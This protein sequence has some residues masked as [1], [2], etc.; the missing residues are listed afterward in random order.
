MLI[1]LERAQGSFVSL[2]K[3]SFPMVRQPLCLFVGNVFSLCLG[4]W[5]GG[6]GGKFLSV[7]FLC[8][9]PL[10]GYLCVSRASYVYITVLKYAS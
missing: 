10:C 3:L 9:S 6:R 8:F 7:C 2:A 4:K 1:I 5:D